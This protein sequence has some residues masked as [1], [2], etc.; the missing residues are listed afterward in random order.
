MQISQRMMSHLT[1]L[2]LIKYDEERYLNQFILAHCT[3][4]A[5][6]HE[7]NSFVTMAIFW[8]PDLP[9]FKG[10]SDHLWHSIFKFANVPHMNDPASI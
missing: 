5:P 6:Q 8:V 10:F 2:V 4:Y 7:L 1:R 3:K 9:K